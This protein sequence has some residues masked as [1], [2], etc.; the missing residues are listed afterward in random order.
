MSVIIQWL[1]SPTH[2]ASVI[3]RL[4]EVGGGRFMTEIIQLPVCG[5]KQITWHTQRNV[6]TF[7]SSYMSEKKKS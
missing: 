7:H 4:G 3:G 2:K 6:M 5:Q 1:L